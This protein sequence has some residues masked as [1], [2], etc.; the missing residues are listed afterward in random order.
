MVHGIPATTRFELAVTFSPSTNNQLP[1]SAFKA[2]IIIENNN[3]TIAEILKLGIAKA[4]LKFNEFLAH[5]KTISPVYSDFTLEAAQAIKDLNLVQATYDSIRTREDDV[6]T[7]SQLRAGI[8]QSFSELKQNRPSLIGQLVVEE[9][10]DFASLRKSSGSRSKQNFF[11]FSDGKNLFISTKSYGGLSKRF[12]KVKSIGRYLL[13]IDDYVTS[14]EMAAGV[15]FGLIGAL[16]VASYNDCIA[17]DMKTGGVFMVTKDKLPQMLSGHD[18]LLNE[19][20]TLPNPGNGQQQ[21]RLLDKLN[22]LSSSVIPH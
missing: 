10:N 16:A 1:G 19:L 17:L 7:C 18:D 21:F 11:G 12:A 15:T 3:N 5:P 4:F 2:E 9:K 22:Q 13:W 20:A 8:Y 6:L 14:T